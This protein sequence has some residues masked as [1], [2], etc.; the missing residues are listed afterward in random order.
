M[1]ALLIKVGDIV[2][3]CIGFLNSRG[4]FVVNYLMKLGN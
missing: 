4:H 2:H 3:I 1:S